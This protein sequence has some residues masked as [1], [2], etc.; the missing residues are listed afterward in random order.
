MVETNEVRKNFSQLHEKSKR[1][2]LSYSS[3]GEV[4]I[5][6]LTKVYLNSYCN[7]NVFPDC[8]RGFMVKSVDGI[9]T[10]NRLY[11]QIKAW[12]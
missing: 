5:L 12:R 4:L 9:L 2:S 8:I 6:N 11:I 10:K 3:E 1:T 7:F